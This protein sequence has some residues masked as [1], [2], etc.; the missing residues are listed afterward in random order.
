MYFDQS[1][2]SCSHGS[3]V[4]L[5][6]RSELEGSS[7][8]CTRIESHSPFSLIC[9]ALSWRFLRLVYNRNVHNNSSL[10]AI[11]SYELVTDLSLGRILLNA[12]LDVLVQSAVLM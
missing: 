8:P 11:D 10:R 3:R 6:E 1:G 7:T 2:Y 5:G 9:G 12:S 4:W